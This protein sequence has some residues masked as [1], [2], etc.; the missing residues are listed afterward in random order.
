M[1]FTCHAY[2]DHTS[3]SPYENHD[4]EAIPLTSF[5][6]PLPTLA[7]NPTSSTES[8]D[9]CEHVPENDEYVHMSASDNHNSATT[10]SLLSPGKSTENGENCSEPTFATFTI[11]TPSK[12]TASPTIAMATIAIPSTNSLQDIEY[13]EVGHDA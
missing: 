6:P 4:Y 13:D 7:S 5:P 10:T 11:D 2:G 8:G 1:L 3:E 9:E 12:T